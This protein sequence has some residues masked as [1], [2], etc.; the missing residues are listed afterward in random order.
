[1]TQEPTV[2]IAT[3]DVPAAADSAFLRSWE[4][5]RD[6]LMSQ[7]GY[8]SSQLHRSIS[9]EDQTRFVGMSAWD[10]ADACRTATSSAQKRGLSV[11]YGRD[12]SMFEI[13]NADQRWRASASV[14]VRLAS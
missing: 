10:S 9:T 2:L 3:F 6:F 5:T 14:P 7:D 1:M 4:R 13:V 11:P 8:R 12:T